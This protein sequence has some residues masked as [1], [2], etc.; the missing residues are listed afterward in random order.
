MKAY[1]KSLTAAEAI[2]FEEDLETKTILEKVRISQEEDISWEMRRSYYALDH[3]KLE[4]KKYFK[5]KSRSKGQNPLCEELF[6]SHLA[7]NTDQSGCPIILSSE[8]RNYATRSGTPSNLVEEALR[9]R[10][11]L[12]A[13]A[14]L[15]LN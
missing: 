6:P 3:D 11:N 2:V 10:H 12:P 13:R 15:V 8:G 7:Y 14:R 9:V 5:W 1:L 4:V